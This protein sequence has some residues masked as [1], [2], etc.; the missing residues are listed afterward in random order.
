MRK[1]AAHP[2][3]VGCARLFVHT[4]YIIERMVCGKTPTS[5]RKSLGRLEVI[6]S[7]L[8][9]AYFS[10]DDVNHSSAIPNKLTVTKPM[11]TL[12]VSFRKTFIKN[13]PAWLDAGVGVTLIA[14][15]VGQ[16]VRVDVGV[17]VGVGTSV[18]VR[19]TSASFL[20]ST[21]AGTIKSS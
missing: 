10:R 17:D 13:S 9:P 15:R 12:N 18:G 3:N 20:F 8:L 14:V 11:P 4:T 6:R 19:V 16:G 1:D 21:R 5:S 2:T 7:Y